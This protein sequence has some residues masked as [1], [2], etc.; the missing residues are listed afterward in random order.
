M[1]KLLTY[2]VNILF[3]ALLK[4]VIYNDPILNFVY[5]NQDICVY[6]FWK[7]EAV[8]SQLWDI[9]PGKNA[10]KPSRVDARRA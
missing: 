9:F 4:L 3:L 2:Y 8:V 1:F 10:G 6:S 5:I 7:Y